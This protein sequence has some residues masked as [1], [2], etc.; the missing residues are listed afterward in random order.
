MSADNG[1]N[2]FA[3]VRMPSSAVEKVAPG[4]KLI[5]SGMVAD[6]LELIHAQETENI[7]QRGV[8]CCLANEIPHDFVEAVRLFRQAAE[9]GHAGAMDRLGGCYRDG[10]G[11]SQDYIEA[12]KW[13]REAAEKDD[14][15]GLI[16][17]GICY[18]E[19]YGVPQD[20]HEAYKFYKL[21]SKNL[22]GDFRVLFKVRLDKMTAFE[23]AEGER[24][25]HEFCSQKI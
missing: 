6:T 7:F 3:L 19:G 1:K 5:L 8:K 25:Y 22:S 18:D 4:V 10:L 23:I 14:P 2:G 13:F 9:K 20:V 17:L 21:G 16:N 15:F 11:V 12:L 24:R